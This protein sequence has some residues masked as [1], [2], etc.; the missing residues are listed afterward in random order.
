MLASGG[1]SGGEGSLISM[2]GSPL[3]VATDIA[4]SIRSAAS[5]N[6]VYGF[7]PSE[8]RLPLLGERTTDPG[9]TGI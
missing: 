7:K 1:S 3:G 9:K 6:G 4:G 5:Y 8:R 2:F